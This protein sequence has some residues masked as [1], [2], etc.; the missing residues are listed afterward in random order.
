[1]PGGKG[2]L[3][4]IP[5]YHLADAALMFA[6][7]GLE[8]GESHGSVNLPEPRNILCQLIILYEPSVFRLIASDDAKVTFEQEFRPPSGFLP[9]L[10]APAFF[11]ND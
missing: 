10:I 8:Q 9:A 1:M 4:V 6:C 11:L 2:D 5:A 3:G 7:Q